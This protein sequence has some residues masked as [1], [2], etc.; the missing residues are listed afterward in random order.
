MRML[1]LR[2]LILVVHNQNSKVSRTI[3]K[4]CRSLFS[5]PIIGQYNLASVK[6][7][8]QDVDQ[9]SLTFDGILFLTFSFGGTFYLNFSFEGN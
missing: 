1:C 5:P 7:K 3:L 4:S 6:T 2:Y 8:V 9:T